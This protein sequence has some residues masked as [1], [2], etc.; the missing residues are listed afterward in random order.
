VR[1]LQATLTAIHIDTRSFPL[2]GEL[3]EDLVVLH[4]GNHLVDYT[5]GGRD[6]SLKVTSDDSRTDLLFTSPVGGQLYRVP[7]H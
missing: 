3:S 5:S 7:E 4:P 1:T 2:T 6:Y